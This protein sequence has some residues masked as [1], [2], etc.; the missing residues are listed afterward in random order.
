MN[1]FEQLTTNTQQA[2]Q[3]LFEKEIPADQI[4][5]TP[6]KADFEGNFT[7]VI[8]ALLKHLRGNPEQIGEQIGSYLQEHSDVVSDF[9]VVKGF[10]NL[11][12][13]NHYWTNFIRKVDSSF[14]QLPKKGNT[15]VLEYCGPNT[16]KP[17]HL[18]HV[19]NML[20]GWSTAEILQ[21]AGNEV[22]KVNIYNDRGIAISKS[23]VAWEMFGNEETPQSSG[24]KGDHFVGKY[25][26]KFAQEEEK[27]AQPFIAEGIDKR[28][29]VKQTT[30]HKK[31][32]EYLQKWE[33]GDQ[34]VLNLWKTMNN[35]V[36]EGFKTTFNNIGV[37]FEKD[38]LESETY[39]LGKKIVEQG[40]EDGVFF[41]KEDGSV[42]VNLED[43]GLDEKILL[44]ADGTSVY[45]TQ[46]L[47][48]AQLRYNDYKMDESIYVV[49][50]EQ[51]YH[52]QVLKAT[53]K[54]LGKPFAEGICHLSY[55]M[56]DLPD[57]KMKSREGTVVDADDI[58]SEM[59]QTAQTHT[60]ELG[61]VD[62][63]TEEQKTELYSML[64]SGALKF[65]ILRVDAKKR[66]LF[67][68][69]ESIEFQGFTGPFVQYTHARIQSLLDKAEFDAN[70]AIPTEIELQKEEIEIIQLLH[71]YP[72]TLTTAAEQRDPSVMAKYAYDIAKTFNQF[73]ANIHVNNE[74]DEQKRRFRLH[75]VSK[76]GNAIRKSLALLGIQAP[77]RM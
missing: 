22:H 34:H 48:T 47:G 43:A 58:I 75:L 68:P 24:M 2:I 50:N 27:Q 67:N 53:L 62:N 72:T 39:L 21:H 55:G 26:V 35:W 3:H 33:D 76:T 32:Q 66:I 15:V 25:Y 37:D 4:S 20:V 57:G 77:N 69:K 28:E 36:Y 16:N 11:T 63:F 12:I 54:K 9:N 61:K 45:I 6:T 51:D 49:G 60:E 31:A 59:K 70:S 10:L 1:L 42:W 71:D 73:Y 5:I 17:L 65:F 7:I 30:I 56:V 23:M 18:G 14:W 64:G 46:D 40:V 29:A 44:R 52:F 74:E 41:K 38:Y 19:R 8:F 13:A